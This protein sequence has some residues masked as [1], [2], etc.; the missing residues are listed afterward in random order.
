MKTREKKRCKPRART[1]GLPPCVT[2]SKS[3]SF[4]GS[5]S[6]AKIGDLYSMTVEVLLDHKHHDIWESGRWVYELH[7][8]LGATGHSVCGMA[9]TCG[10]TANTNPGPD[11][12][13]GR[14]KVLAA[15]TCF[16]LLL[17]DFVCAYQ[18]LHKFPEV[19]SLP[20]SQLLEHLS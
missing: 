10:K 1:S 6:L 9:F 14:M 3:P 8:H 7:L 2:L 15:P 5:P 13:E 12:S 16:W 19:V 4:P 20:H 11:Q 18:A 17:L